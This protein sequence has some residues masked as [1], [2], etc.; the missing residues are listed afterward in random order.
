MDKNY[1]DKNGNLVNVENKSLAEIYMDGAKYNLWIK[2]SDQ[3]PNEYV[4][5]IIATYGTD[6]IMTK[7]G[8]S[9][10]D[11]IRRSRREIVSVSCGFI[12][13]DGW[14][15]WYGADMYP[16]IVQPT[17]WM[18]MPTAPEAPKEYWNVNPKPPEKE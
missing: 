16:L 8:E 1:F 4:I 7:D 18:P 6:M 17:Y 12:G 14:Y 3:L 5:V 10:A 15:G 13:S 9:L 11:A 2:C